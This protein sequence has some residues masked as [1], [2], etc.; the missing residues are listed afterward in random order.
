MIRDSKINAGGDSTTLVRVGKCTLTIGTTELDL[1]AGSSA[2]S[3]SIG[4]DATVRADRLHVHGVTTSIIQT[5]G[6][7]INFIITG[8]LLENAMFNWITTDTTSP[9]SLAGAAFNTI[10]LPPAAEL[11]CQTNSGS[12]NRRTIYEDDVV[13]EHRDH[14]D[15][16]G[17]GLHAISQ[18]PVSRAS[19]PTD[20]HLARSSVCRSE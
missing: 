1:G 20:Q 3:M 15:G 13:R 6:D 18:H 19:C 5:F 4:T 17:Y 7:H 11:Y 9:G 14:L 2:A 16:A 8:S 10:V 12:A